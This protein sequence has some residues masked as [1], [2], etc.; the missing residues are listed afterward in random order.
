MEWPFERTGSSQNP[1][2]DPTRGFEKIIR[3]S[4]WMNAI[5]PIGG[6]VAVEQDLHYT[7][8]VG[9]GPGSN[10]EFL[11]PT[12]FKSFVRPYELI[13]LSDGVYVGRQ[14][15]N[16]IGM[17]NSRIGF[18]HPGKNN[19]ANTAFADG[20]VKGIGGRDFPR[21]LGGSNLPA[22]VVAENTGGRPSVYANPE[23]ALGL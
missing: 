17:P 11:K 23:K 18:R 2:T 13:A 9:Y 3:V 6:T 12:Y 7:G 10:G 4:Y 5:N 22:E 8:S 14:R 15:D 19:V 16:Q 21:A 20:H 1:V